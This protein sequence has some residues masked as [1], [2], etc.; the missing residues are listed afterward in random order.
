MIA[1]G[2]V[3]SHTVT[4]MFLVVD[5]PLESVTVTGT[6][7]SADEFTFPQEICPDSDVKLIE[8]LFPLT[9]A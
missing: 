4:L 9:T 8:Y 5:I 7:K 3:Q 1:V 2:G 6:V